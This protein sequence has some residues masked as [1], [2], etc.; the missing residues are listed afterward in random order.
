MSTMAVLARYGHVQPDVYRAM[1]YTEAAE[2]AK[3]V[4]DLWTEEKRGDYEFH[5]E[6]TKILVRASGARIL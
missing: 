3:R 5:S 1:D 2:L 4:M 6:L